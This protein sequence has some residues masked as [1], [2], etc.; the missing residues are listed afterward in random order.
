LLYVFG[1]GAQARGQAANYNDVTITTTCSWAVESTSMSTSLLCTERIQSGRIP[2]YAHCTGSDSID[3][4]Q[5][6][7][8]RAWA[9]RSRANTLS[10]KT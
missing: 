3:I 4:H 10:D 5:P 2:G 7:T 1:V 8:Q 6:V 9:S